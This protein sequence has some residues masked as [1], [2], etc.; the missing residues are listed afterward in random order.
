MT[1]WKN[2]WQRSPRQDR[3]VVVDGKFV[4]LVPLPGVTEREQS[5]LEVVVEPVNV[6]VQEQTAEISYPTSSLGE[7]APDE[8][9]YSAF[10][11]DGPEHKQ[12]A[13]DLRDEMANVCF[14]AMGMPTLPSESEKLQDDLEPLPEDKNGTDI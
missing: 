6:P 11:L 7:H 9:N 14:K 12:A 8:E 10:N 5:A 13:E 3:R 4:E 2:K 1:D